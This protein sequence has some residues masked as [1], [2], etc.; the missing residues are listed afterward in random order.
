MPPAVTTGVAIA[1][2]IENWAEAWFLNMILS[3]VE[4][5]KLGPDPLNHVT[6]DHMLSF[7]HSILP[8]YL[9]AWIG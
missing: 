2:N 7:Q 6:T 8:S 4:E 3:K 1:M 9:I 5:R